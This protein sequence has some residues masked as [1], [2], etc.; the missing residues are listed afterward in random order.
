[1]L[2]IIAKVN[3]STVFFFN[4]LKSKT[5]LKVPFVALIPMSKD[6]K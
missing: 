2:V 3:I 5:L 6:L 1:M 4:I